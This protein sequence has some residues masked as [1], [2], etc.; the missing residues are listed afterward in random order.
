MDCLR[1]GFFRHDGVRYVIRGVEDDANGSTT[2]ILQ[3]VGD[4]GVIN[5]LD[6]ETKSVDSIDSINSNSYTDNDVLGYEDNDDVGGFV[7]DP[8]G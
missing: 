5:D 1:D 6:R 8:S 2:I 7:E 3:I 4:D